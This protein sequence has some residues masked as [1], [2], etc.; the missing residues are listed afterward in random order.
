MIGHGYISTGD[1]FLIAAILYMAYVLQFLIIS[2][3]Y[4]GDDMNSSR[5][6]YRHWSR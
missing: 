1:I 2:P 6:R 5:D 3:K 4:P